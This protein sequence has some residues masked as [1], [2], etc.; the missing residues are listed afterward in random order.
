MSIFLDFRRFM[1]K[2]QS[3]RLSLRNELCVVDALLI[4]SGYGPATNQRPTVNAPDPGQTIGKITQLMRAATRSL[5]A[6]RGT[7]SRRRS[8]RYATAW[9][10]SAR[11]RG[12]PSSPSK[13]TT[14]QAGRHQYF[15]KD[16][17]YVLNAFSHL[18]THHNAVGNLA[19]QFHQNSLASS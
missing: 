1:G 2:S 11:T 19:G 7:G 17:H 3:A 5:I 18:H 10:I 12:T 4:H 14:V 13:S 8:L 16:S 6:S 15:R 9:Q